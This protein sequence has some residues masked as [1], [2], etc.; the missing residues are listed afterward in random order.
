MS[1]YPWFVILLTISSIFY[2]IY[3]FKRASTYQLDLNDVL[4]LTA[5]ATFIIL[6][7]SFPSIGLII[8][9]LVGI[10]YPHVVM[11]G[12]LFLVIFAFMHKVAKRLYKLEKSN[13]I[14]IQELALLE[15][16]LKKQS[17]NF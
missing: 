1:L 2:I 10:K 6:F 17:S 12:G 8:S 3:I 14:L 13:K 4:S 9:E 15:I 16:E 5:I 11:F 7:I